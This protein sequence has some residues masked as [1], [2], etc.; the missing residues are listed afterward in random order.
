MYRVLFRIEKP[1]LIDKLK[2][3]ITNLR[4][5]MESEKKKLV[6]EV[7]FSGPVVNYFKGDYSD[8]KDP[9]L[10]IALCHNALTGAKMDDIFD[11]N[12]RTVKAGIGEII[13]KK[14]EGWIE[15]TIE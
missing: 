6:I 5:Y 3:K 1:E 11:E 8:F 7:V 13:E 14:A 4:H 2:A 9:D 12:I 10:D 15:Y